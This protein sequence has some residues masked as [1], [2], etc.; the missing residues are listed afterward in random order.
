[1]KN[2][3]I[4]FILFIALFLLITNLFAQSI[5]VEEYKLNNGLTIILNEDHTNPEV[6]GMVA[7]KAGGKNDPDDATGMAHYQEHVLF[8]GTQEL[9]TTD[10]EK[11][12]PYIEKIYNLYDEL[13]KTDDPV[14]REEIQMQINEESLKAGE[15][16]IPNEF[17]NLIRSIGG[18]DLNAGTGPDMTVYYNKFPPNQMEKWMELYSHRFINPVFRSFQAELE[19]VYEEKNMGNDN[20]VIPL[21][22]EFNRNFFKKHPYGQQ[23][24]IGT[25]DDLKNPSLTKMYDFFKTYYVAN[26]MALILSGDFETEKVKPL[27]EEKFGKWRKGEIPEP[28]KYIEEPFN[29]RELVVK[30]MSPVKLAILGFRTP[31]KGDD[32]EIILDVCNGILSN[33]N[34]TGLLDKL[35]LGNKVMAAEIFP[36]AYN[37]YGSTMIFAVPKI[38]GQK[39]ESTETLLLAQLDSLRSGNFEDWMVDAVKKELYKNFELELESNEFKAEIFAEAFSQNRN[40]NDVLKYPEKI[41]KVTKEDVIR[42]ANKY[43]GKNYLAFYSKM[44]FPK[45]EKI[46]KPDFEPLD[47]NTNAK[48]VFAG[49]FE[50][51][52][53]DEPIEKFV[54]FEKDVK[55]AELGKLQTLYVVNNP[56]ND[57]FT[58]TIK[59]GI[60]NEKSP[61]LKYASDMMNYAGTVDFDLSQYKNEFSKSGCSYNIYSNDSYT[62]IELDGP[63]DNLTNALKLISQLLVSPVL[64]PEKL[65]ILLNEEKTIRKLERSEPDNVADALYE[66][67]RYK[68]N[69]NYIDRLSLKELK[70]LNTDSLVNAFL[71]V[72]K[73]ET[74]VHYCGKTGITEFKNIVSANLQLTQPVYKSESPVVR[75][76]EKYSSNKIY[77]VD[78]KKALQSKIYFLINGKQYQIDEDPDIDAFN[79]YFGGGFSGL[80][81]QEIREYRSMAYSA[82]A[83]FRRPPLQGKEYYFVGYIGTQADKTNGAIDVFV[84]LVRNMPEKSERMPM[85]RD[86]LKQSALTSRPGFRELSETV[87][88]WKLKG[89]TDDPAKVKIPGYK[90]H[91]F[92]DITRFYTENIKEKPMVICIVGDEKRIDMDELKKYGEIIYVKESSLFTK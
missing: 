33:E 17:S 80:V 39:L 8:K 1:M 24:L 35:V 42:M 57:I 89:Y 49:R 54:D 48:S 91:T 14:K 82:G 83:L 59:F 56:K 38:I 68:N 66:Y 71:N 23:T 21:F 52:K 47:A 31:A 79:M 86:Y 70:K 87:V 72:T 50:K 73:Y 51:M 13:G 88:K 2:L 4:N 40:I 20:F 15:Y 84:D 63:E 78:K 36:I 37:D 12:K 18:T 65:D 22:E 30:K 9:G 5:K 16:A 53:A 46:D 67:I 77:F 75:N 92:N 64:K 25:V 45:K 81:L 43:Y 90:K 10:W 29:G 55:T 28:K 60:G 27:I 3:K 41:K 26:N 6:F 44:G 74:E 61:L 32:D 85:I 7:V 62:Y 11:E 34:S 69:S 19:I 76:V 58:L